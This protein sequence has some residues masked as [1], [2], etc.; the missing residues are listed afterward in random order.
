MTL[1]SSSWPMPLCVKKMPLLPFLAQIPPTPCI[2]WMSQPPS[3]ALHSP[4]PQTTSL[5]PHSGMGAPMGKSV[6]LAPEELRP[7]VA[8]TGRHVFVSICSCYSEPRGS[9]AFFVAKV[10]DVRWTT[11][12]FRPFNALLAKHDSLDG[13]LCPTMQGVPV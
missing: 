10:S 7:Y 4:S 3:R 8:R 5:R 2:A 6:D 11:G 13:K 1:I 12:S 9:T